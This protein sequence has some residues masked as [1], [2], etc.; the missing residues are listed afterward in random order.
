MHTALRA[1]SSP[2]QPA[3]PGACSLLFAS[4]SAVSCLFPYCFAATATKHRQCCHSHAAVPNPNKGLS[5]FLSLNRSSLGMAMRD[6]PTGFVL[7]HQVGTSQRA[8]KCRKL[9]WL[10]LLGAAACSC[11]CRAH[12]AGI[13][14]RELG[15]QAQQHAGQEG[16]IT[17]CWSSPSCAAPSACDGSVLLCCMQ[18]AIRMLCSPD[19]TIVCE[20]AEFNQQ[21][22]LA[23]RY[24]P[25]AGF[26]NAE[27]GLQPQQLSVIHSD[28]PAPS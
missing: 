10:G 13:A 11:L 27:A 26:S 2:Q 14:T 16:Q 17:G 4:L 23:P 3:A 15:T 28:V 20:P 7:E 12:R 6:Q 5:S 1:P 25:L 19:G 22:Q 18:G 21:H 8:R 24:S 9:S